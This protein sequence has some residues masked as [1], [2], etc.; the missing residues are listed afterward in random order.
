[1]NKFRIGDLVKKDNSNYFVKSFIYDDFYNCYLYSI[2]HNTG[3]CGNVPEAEL[4]LVSPSEQL[5]VEN[6]IKEQHKN[7]HIGGGHFKLNKGEKIIFKRP[8][9]WDLGIVESTYEDKVFIRDKEGLGYEFYLDE[10]IPCSIAVEKFKEELKNKINNIDEFFT[11][12]S[13]FYDK[14]SQIKG[15]TQMKKEILG[16]LE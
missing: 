8:Y 2:W 12:K 1:M 10:V 14:E 4:E 5:A 9:Q 15:A 7:I 6:Y 11:T 16:L 13:K 3:M